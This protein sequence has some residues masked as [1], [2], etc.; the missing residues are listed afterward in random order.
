M[1][2]LPTL[3]K[4]H[5]EAWLFSQL[6]ERAFDYMDCRR[7]VIGSYLNEHLTRGRNEYYTCSLGTYSLR[8]RNGT[9]IGCNETPAWLTKLIDLWDG[10][11]GRITISDVRN[12]WLEMFPEPVD[13]P[14]TL[15]PA[16][17]PVSA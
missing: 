7:C 16:K 5:F 4:E 12:R 10:R 9:R 14:L 2:T 17:E 1:K 13:R 3:H 8:Q 11:P 15:T 6:A